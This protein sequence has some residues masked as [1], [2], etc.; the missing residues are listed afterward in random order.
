VTAE[1]GSRVCAVCAADDAY[2]M[3]LAVTLRSAQDG[4]A[5]GSC[6]DV[7]VIDGGLRP[8]SRERVLRSLDPERV[9]V[10]F[11]P[12]ETRALRGLRVDPG[13]ISLATYYRLLLA[14]VL[15]PETPRALYLDSDLVVAGDLSRLFSLELGGHV[16]LA[17]RDAGLP[18]FGAHPR[19]G[20]LG[21][22][23]LAPETPYFNAGVMLVDGPRWRSQRVAE[24][25]LEHL[26]RHPRENRF[27]DQDGLNA[28][29]A[30]GFGEL[31]PRWN[32]LPQLHAWRSWR[33]NPYGPERCE[34]A[35]ADPWIV[36]FATWS[37]P[38]HFGD[39]HPERAR[40]FAALDR[41]AFSG[42]RPRRGL[43]DTALARR[44]GRLR[45]RARRLVA[46]G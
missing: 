44:F 39:A 30:G 10:R 13:R 6:L 20:S 28:V 2:A 1:L 4:L 18:S 21:A 40:F 31:D 41:T 16:L 5:P 32:Q 14:L 24:R 9:A 34:A 29:L 35:L 26:A 17:A 25:V 23:A 8:A 3:P 12:A 42:W 15:P 33:E 37:K 19:P 36:H 22:G 7:T 38:W 43:R 46:G 45:Q 27:H 11:A